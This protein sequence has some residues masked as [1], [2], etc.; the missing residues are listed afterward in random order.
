MGMKKIGLVIIILAC[1]AVLLSGAQYQ[2]SPETADQP[3]TNTLCSGYTIIE[4]GKG[5]DCH[6][7]TIPLIKTNGFY[8]A[9][10]RIDKKTREGELN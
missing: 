6:G 5:I 7:D 3:E 8:E 2:A 10:A 4:A 9:V 1:Y